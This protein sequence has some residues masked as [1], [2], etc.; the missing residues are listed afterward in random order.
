MSRV[1]TL[2][3][4]GDEWTYDKDAR[5][6]NLTRGASPSAFTLCT[7]KGPIDTSITLT[8][9]LSALVVV[10]MQN[11]F[12]H[13]NCNNYPTGLVAVERTLELI[14]KCREIDLKIIWLNWGLNDE[15]LETMPAA[16]ER[17]FN[18]NLVATSLDSQK[19]RNGFG[20]DMGEGRGRML[21]EGSWNAAL[22]DALRDVARDSDI[23]CSKNR[24]SGFWHG[25]TPFGKALNS[26]GFR[27]LLFAG[28]NTDQ[29]VL[30][31]LADAYY[32]GHDC[33]M[34]EDCCATRT[35]GGQEV[36]IY[37]AAICGFVVWACTWLN[38]RVGNSAA[39]L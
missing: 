31:T 7:T 4:R 37:N 12:L 29:C 22:Y 16:A 34:V 1:V 11:F 30:G 20:S 2:G 32:R 5:V 25:E 19:I 24:V 8:P 14:R 35:P 21:M 17:S 39:T 28:V 6:Y 36:T 26:G 3:P 18:R 10:D 9:S 15:D 33:I 27:S 23:F 13:P 38:S